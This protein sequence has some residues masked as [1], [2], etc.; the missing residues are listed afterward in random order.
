MKF[1]IQVKVWDPLKSEYV[2]FWL[3]SPGLPRYEWESLMEANRMK[4]MCYPL[5]TSDWVRVT[6]IVEES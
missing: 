3:H 6:E 4:E 5:T 2:W 1:G